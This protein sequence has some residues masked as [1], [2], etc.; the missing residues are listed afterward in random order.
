MKQAARVLGHVEFREGDGPMMVIRPGAVEVEVTP[1]D[2]TLSW[3]DGAVRGVA[4][5]PHVNYQRYVENGLIELVGAS[6]QT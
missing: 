4:A 1:S 6:R 5:M 3:T 2:V